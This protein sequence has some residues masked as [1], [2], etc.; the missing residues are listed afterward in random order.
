MWNIDPEHFLDAVREARESEADDLI[1]Y[2]YGWADERLFE[3]ESPS[4][5]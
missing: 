1:Y 5:T 4:M 3:A 2:C